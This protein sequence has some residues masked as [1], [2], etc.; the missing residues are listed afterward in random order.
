MRPVI[1]QAG[2][3]FHLHVFVISTLKPSPPPSGEKGEESSLRTQ[4]ELEGDAIVKRKEEGRKEEEEGIDPVM[5]KYMELVTQRRKQQKMQVCVCVCEGVYCVMLQDHSS[6][7]EQKLSLGHDEQEP[8]SPNSNGRD[9]GL[10]SMSQE[11]D[12][13]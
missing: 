7:E 10:P 9:Y 6:R 13:R 11:S 1:L 4:L 5:L 3:L 8:P 12:K 2:T